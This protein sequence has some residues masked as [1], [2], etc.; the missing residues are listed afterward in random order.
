MTRKKSTILLKKIF[1]GKEN[2][3]IPIQ[4]K[5]NGINKLPETRRQ[6]GFGNVVLVV[7]IL[8]DYEMYL[9]T[10]IYEREQGWI[11]G[12]PSKQFQFI[13]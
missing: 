5:I 12:S 9:W 4:W 3:E 11:L 10:G 13:E 7:N 2:Y 8:A 6:Y 1:L